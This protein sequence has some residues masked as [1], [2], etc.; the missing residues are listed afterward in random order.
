MRDKDDSDNEE[1]LQGRRKRIQEQDDKHECVDRSGGDNRNENLDDSTEHI[2]E[3]WVRNSDDDH[4]YRDHDSGQY[5]DINN[6]KKMNGNIDQQKNNNGDNSNTDG[7]VLNTCSNNSA[8]IAST[9]KRREVKPAIDSDNKGFK[10]KFNY[11]SN[12]KALVHAR[13]GK[14]TPSSQSSSPPSTSL[15]HIVGGAFVLV[16]VAM[17]LYGW[18]VP[19]LNHK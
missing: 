12:R 1:K 3:G 6:I 18:G 17:T 4:D 19:R 16:L 2:T 9:V 15:K 11:K 10:F 8:N 13:N 14:Q 5:R 7:N